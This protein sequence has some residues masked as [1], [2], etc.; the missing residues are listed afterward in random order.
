VYVEGD[1]L[2][3]KFRATYIDQSKCA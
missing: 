1:E 2:F 3:D